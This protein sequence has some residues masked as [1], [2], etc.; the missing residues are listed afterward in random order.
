M[1]CSPVTPE[2][3]LSSVPGLFGECSHSPSPPDLAE[4][5][6]WGFAGTHLSEIQKQMIEKG[7]I[8]EQ[9]PALLPQWV[10]GAPGKPSARLWSIKMGYSPCPQPASLSLYL[11]WVLVP[12]GATHLPPGEQWGDQKC[13]ITPL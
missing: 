11:L 2:P 4:E 7:E 6:Q 5:L 10:L 13:C 3:A 8:E 12:L 9:V 1:C